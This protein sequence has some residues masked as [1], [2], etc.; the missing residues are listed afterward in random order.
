MKYGQEQLQMFETK[1]MWCRPKRRM[2]MLSLK[3]V[4]LLQRPEY[5]GLGNEEQVY[6]FVYKNLDIVN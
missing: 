2:T 3:K 6:I 5:H 1:M 4:V